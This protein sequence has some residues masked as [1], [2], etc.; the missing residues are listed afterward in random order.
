VLEYGKDFNGTQAAI[1][2]G[3]SR[4][5]AY[6]IAWENLRKPEIKA[7][8]ETEF[9]KR[10]IGL[11]EVL[12]RLSEQATANIG[13]FVVVNPDGDRIAFDPEMLK[14]HGR[15][16]KRVRAKTTVKFDAKGDQIE[17][18]TLELELYDAQ[19]ALETLGRHMG[20]V[21][22]RV[23]VDWRLEAAKRGIRASEVFEAMVNEL[24]AR[25]PEGGD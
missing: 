22:G 3:Y 20:M 5:T 12:A 19:R 1:R 13:D 8:I 6:S 17:Y 15:M 21:S 2:A 18:T 10:T 16:V 23:E 4:K 11:D 25:L 7:E 24:S 14:A 9:R